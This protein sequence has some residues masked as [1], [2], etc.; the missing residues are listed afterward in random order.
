ME[1]I[2]LS[3]LKILHYQVQE[4]SSLKHKVSENC[5]KLKHSLQ[6]NFVLQEMSLIILEFIQPLVK[7][8]SK[9]YLKVWQ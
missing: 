2:S 5:L 7:D 8:L 3:K 6:N 4:L 1:L 9:A